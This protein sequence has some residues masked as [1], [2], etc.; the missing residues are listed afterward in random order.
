MYNYIYICMWMGPLYR[1][2]HWAPEKSG[3]TLPTMHTEFVA[4]HE[5]NGQ[6]I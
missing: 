1:I 6:A 5:A 3:T 2:S 4:M